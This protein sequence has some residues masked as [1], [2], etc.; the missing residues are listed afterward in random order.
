MIQYYVGAFFA[1]A[2]LGE[3]LT[4]WGIVGASLITI[5]A[6]TNAFLELGEKR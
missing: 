5:A 6:A 3:Q 4:E 2:I 1:F